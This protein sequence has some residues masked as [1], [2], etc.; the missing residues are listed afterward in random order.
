VDELDKLCFDY[1]GAEENYYFDYELSEEDGYLY[2]YN[3][4]IFVESPDDFVSDLEM[5][6]EDFAIE[7]DY[8]FVADGLEDEDEA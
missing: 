5:L 3:F 8:D 6:C 2:L 4:E 7:G 1:S